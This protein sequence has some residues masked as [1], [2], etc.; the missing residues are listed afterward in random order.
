MRASAQKELGERNGPVTRAATG[1]RGE[2]THSHTASL[3]FNFWKYSRKAHAVETS[4][5]YS[6]MLW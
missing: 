2:G 5:W 4:I 3:S 1:L 6:E